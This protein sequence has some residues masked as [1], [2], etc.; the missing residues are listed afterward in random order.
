[1][2][3]FRDLNPFHVGVNVSNHAVVADPEFVIG[4]SAQAFKVDTW[5]VFGGFQLPVNPDR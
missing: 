4:P 5:V 1:M 3:D 2:A